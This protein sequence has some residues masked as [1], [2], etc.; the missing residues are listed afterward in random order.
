MKINWRVRFRNRVWLA[1]F[2]AAAVSFAY[3]MLEMFGMAPRLTED[4]VMQAVNVVLMV[5]SAL[6]VVMDPT[7]AGLG[8]SER[9]MAYEEPGG[10][11]KETEKGQDRP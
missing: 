10:D 4:A 8:D 9:A 6:G 11:G 2:L 1:G 5:L 3:Q 7:T